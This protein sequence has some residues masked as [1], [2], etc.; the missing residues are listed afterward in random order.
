M[1]KTETNRFRSYLPGSGF[2]S[3][4]APVQAKQIRVGFLDVTS[5]SRGGE[6][7]T[8]QDVGL[9]TIDHLDLRLEDPV[10]GPNP[11]QKT[12]MAVYS[13]AAQEF[14]VI[15]RQADGVWNELADTTSINLTF[16]AF[17]DSAEDQP[18]L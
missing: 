7:L 5:Y 9:V 16:V 11:G 8:A 10:T 18:L 13:D 12:R 15:E 17:G 4:G 14:Y 1:A 6:S 2:D 3:S